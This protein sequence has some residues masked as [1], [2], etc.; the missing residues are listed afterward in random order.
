MT[1]PEPLTRCVTHAC[2]FPAGWEDGHKAGSCG[3][4]NTT[5][6]C[7]FEPE[8]HACSIPDYSYMM[9]CYDP[10]WSPPSYGIPSFRKQQ[11][12]ER[13]LMRH[14]AADLREMLTDPDLDPDSAEFIRKYLG[15]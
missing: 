7:V 14:T 13:W 9:D 4:Q 1:N 12:Y 6:K 15:E 3:E 2:I 5:G 11:E 10:E 8:P